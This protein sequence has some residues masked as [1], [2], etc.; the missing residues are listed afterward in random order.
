MCSAIA[1]SSLVAAP[2]VDFGARRGAG[3]WPG[4]VGGVG[5]GRL[6]RPVPH[7]EACGHPCVPRP[8]GAR[9]CAARAPRG[10][11]LA[12]RPLG[13]RPRTRGPK[14]R[15]LL[16]VPLDSRRPRATSSLV[17]SPRHLSSSRSRSLFACSAVP[18]F[19]SRL[20]RAPRPTPPLY[21]GMYPRTPLP[22]SPSTMSR[23]DGTAR[24]PA[25]TSIE[26]AGAPSV[27]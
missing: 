1:A 10:S 11:G 5:L 9:T 19:D 24:N 13:R 4:E 8:C 14:N 27:L 25:T 7:A 15:K 18:G 12:G 23:T 2:P 17:D 3:P 26:R 16:A 21:P 22:P 6:T 20:P